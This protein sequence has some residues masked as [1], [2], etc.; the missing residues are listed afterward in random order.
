[1]IDIRPIE[2]S[3]W[4]V[5]WPIVQ[6]VTDRGDTYPYDP[7]IDK[8][9]AYRT[10]IESPLA[11]Y[12]ALEQNRVVGTYY[13]K[14]NQPGLGSH[15]CNCGYMVAED[16]RGKGVA[17]R[18]CE[19]SQR[20]AVALG[21]KAMQFNLVVSSNKAAVHLWTKLGFQTVGTL[22]KAFKHKTL[23]YV[24]ALVMYKWLED[25]RPE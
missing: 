19:H 16:A 11:T 24:D 20:E 23:G 8:D 7:G 18:L 4:N 2:E 5:T 9:E 12:V 14:P 15:V 21:F 10:W 1:M 3:D 22:T 25:S 6:S 17:T 13:I